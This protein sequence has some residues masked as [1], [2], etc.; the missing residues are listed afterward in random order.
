[1]IKTIEPFTPLQYI[2]GKEKFFGLDFLVNEDVFIP[3]PETEVLVETTLEIVKGTRH[4]TQDTRILDLCTGSGCIAI[5]LTKN[6]L[7]CKI[8]ASDVSDKA[9]EIAKENAILNGVYDKGSFIKSDLFKNIDGKF[10]IIVSNP[11]YI[12][13]AEFE[14]IQ[15]EVLREPRL[16]LDGGE[17]GLS[18][19][20]RIFDEAPLYLKR[21]GYCMVEIGYGQREAVREIMERQGNFKVIDV[22][23]DQYGIDRVITAKWIN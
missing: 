15:K 18:F 4:E 23:K 17:D 2:I 5:A 1:M 8:L 10:D 20:R 13:R 22:R 19:Y 11:P 7:N 16:A 14:S 12:A 21:G 9:L 6:A 3:R